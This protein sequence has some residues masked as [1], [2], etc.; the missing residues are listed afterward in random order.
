MS[1]PIIFGHS[2]SVVL[3]RSFSIH[4]S[5][6]MVPLNPVGS[7]NRTFTYRKHLKFGRFL[8][9][10][11]NGRDHSKVIAMVL[12]FEKVEKKNINL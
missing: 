10:F 8:S 7:E 11:S 4:L 3:N 2:H 12:T 6:I 9:R 5:G 1:C